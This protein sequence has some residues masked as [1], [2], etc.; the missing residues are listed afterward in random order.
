MIAT[1]QHLTRS[2]QRTVLWQAPAQRRAA[3]KA[4]QSE[5]VVQQYSVLIVQSPSR[6][7]ILRTP[8]V[9]LAFKDGDYWI[10]EAAEIEL[11][12]LARTQEDVPN[13]LGE[14]FEAIWEGIVL[15]DPKALAPKAAALR[16]RMLAIVGATSSL[17]TRG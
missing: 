9:A 16:S 3:P 7:F 14:A 1:E 11:S 2:Q 12:T 6:L 5:R 8:L 17:Q 4:P 13:A 10:V 15:H